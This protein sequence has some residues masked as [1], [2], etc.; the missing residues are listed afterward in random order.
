ML[1]RG[2]RTREILVKRNAKDIMLRDIML[3]RLRVQRGCK[4]DAVRKVFP[5]IAIQDEAEQAFRDVKY[6]LGPTLLAV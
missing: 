4:C 5:T 1:D 2:F 6:S 3:Q